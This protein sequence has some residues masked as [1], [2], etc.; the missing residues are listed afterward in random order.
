[1]TSYIIDYTQPGGRS[2]EMTIHA[3]NIVEA[4]AEFE[5]HEYETNGFKYNVN[6]YAITN[7]KAGYTW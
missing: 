1:M 5:A 6:Q 7:I 3:K 2:D 4:I